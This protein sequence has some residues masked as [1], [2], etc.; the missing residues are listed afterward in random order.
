MAANSTNINSGICIIVTQKITKIYLGIFTTH[1]IATAGVTKTE[2]AL[3]GENDMEV[4][5]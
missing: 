3:G 2:M 4:S 5:K 1:C